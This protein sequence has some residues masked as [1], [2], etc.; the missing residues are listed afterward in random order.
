ML[1]PRILRL[2]ESEAIF[3]CNNNKLQC[4]CGG[5][6]TLTIPQNT[7]STRH[8]SSMGPLK[9][10]LANA[11]QLARQ[12]SPSTPENRDAALAAYYQLTRDYAEKSLTKSSN[13]LPALSSIASAMVPVLGHGY[14]AGIWEC[15]K[16]T[17]L[18]W[19]SYWATGFGESGRE[20]CV[21]HDPN[22]YVAPS[23]SWASRRSGLKSVLDEFG[24]LDPEGSE[25]W[26][27]A[28]AEL[29]CHPAG[30]DPFGELKGGCLTLWT[31]GMPVVCRGLAGPMQWGHMKLT[32][33]GIKGESVFQVD[34]REDMPLIASGPVVCLELKRARVTN[35]RSERS[36]FRGGRMV[37]E[38]EEEEKVSIGAIVVVS[39][40]MNK[41]AWRRVGFAMCS[42]YLGDWKMK[43]YMVV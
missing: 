18:Q 36:V 10:L 8:G 40:P 2:T 4:E 14:H 20:V 33:G 22:T 25:H 1:A 31:C 12:P 28:Q 6:E 7:S 11:L 30:P 17:G 27:Y 15:D 42:R 5:A 35:R 21:R 3:E 29:K 43:E 34:A 19:T 13:L 16:Y 9:P 23:F 24:S 41:G 32:G 37:Y 39:N 26:E 38:R